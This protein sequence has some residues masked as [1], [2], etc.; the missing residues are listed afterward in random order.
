MSIVAR[1][2]QLKSRPVGL[3]S[4]ENFELVER[5]LD[6]PLEGQLLVRN[7]WMS[8]DPYM[9]GR[10]ADRKSYIP[11][12][13][14]GEPLEGTAIGIVEV[15]AARDFEPGELVRHFAGWR[16]HALVEA[17]GAAKI[18]ERLAPPQTYLGALGTPG[19]AA[20]VGLLRIARAQGGDTVFV[21]AGSGA[22]GSMVCQ[23]ARIKGCRV[24]ASAGSDAKVAWLRDEIGVDAAINYRSAGAFEATLAKACPD[25]LD[26]YFDNVGGMQLDAALAVANNFARFVLCGMI[27]Q[28]N[29]EAPPAGPRN[30][31]RAVAK[32][33][34]MQ[35]FII[36]DHMDLMPTFSAEMSRWIADGQVKVRETVV[37]GL[38][39]APQAFLGLFSGDNVGK[40][41]VDLRDDAANAPN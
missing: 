1:E 7:L 2:F 17:A 37:K 23:I 36:T 9:R 40:M 29:A 19:L 31:F 3:P 38:D 4:E 18:D 30:I 35:G 12:F 24:V 32:R 28:Y 34:T 10:M 39:R 5:R 8:V 16:T 26:V 41:I 13:Q 6:K 11:P 33:L 27:E 14:L 15:S 20:Y 22:V 25:G 21:S